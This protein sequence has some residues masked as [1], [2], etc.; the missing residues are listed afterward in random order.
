MT[1]KQ[2]KTVVAAV[3]IVALLV[4]DQIIKIW[5]KTHMTLG[6]QIVIAPW[7]RIQ[8]I[9]NRGMAWGMELGSK[10]FLSLFRIVAVGF[11]IWYIVSLIRRNVK[12][13]YLTMICLIC[14]GAAGNIFDS[15]VY[16][17]IFTA[18][19]PFDVAQL[20]PWGQGY[21]TQL[22]SGSVVDMF[23]FPIWHGILPDWMPIGGGR[24]F[25]FFNAIFNFADACITVGVICLLIFY[26]KTLSTDLDRDRRKGRNGDDGSEN[27][28]PG[29]ETSDTEE[30]EAAQASSQADADAATTTAPDTATA[31]DTITENK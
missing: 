8:F 2:K 13:G 16:G 10:L 5:V 23:Y 7:F 30:V 22:L 18:S 19:T 15:V 25:T 9:E 21:N 29:D 3:L 28:A 4:I 17:Q 20:V 14:A 1:V 26:N 27:D 31:T 6:E 24:E 12:W 11:I